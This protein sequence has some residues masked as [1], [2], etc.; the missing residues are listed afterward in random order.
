MSALLQVATRNGVLPAVDGVAAPL[1]VAGGIPYDATGVAVDLTGVIDHYHQGLPFTANGRL[2]VVQTAPA[3]Y[4]SGAAPFLNE[5][6]TMDTTG[7]DHYSSSI[8]YTIAGGIAV[9]GLAPF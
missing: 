5:R 1:Y 9:E 6:L 4:G 8:P 3:Y 7:I 2:C